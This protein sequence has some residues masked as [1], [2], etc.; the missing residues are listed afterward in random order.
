MEKRKERKRSP[1][2]ERRKKNYKYKNNHRIQNKMTPKPDRK[3]I[4][5]WT[6]KGE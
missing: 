1:E 2:K 5:N 4:A 6:S 3:G